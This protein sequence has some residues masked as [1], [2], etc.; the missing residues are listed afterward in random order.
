[1]VINS[2]YA[3][4]CTK[5]KGSI[6]VG[7]KVVWV[8]TE[9]GVYHADSDKCAPPAEHFQGLPKLPT[10]RPVVQVD[11]S[12]KPLADVM[13][14]V[15]LKRPTLRLNSAMGEIVLS[16]TR[17]GVQPGSVAIKVAGN[18]I[19]CVRPSGE[20]SSLLRNTNYADLRTHLLNIATDKNSLIAAA[21]DYAKL[22]NNCSFCG[23]QLTNDY[24]V[25][26]GYGPICAENWGLPHALNGTADKIRVPGMSDEKHMKMMKM[27]MEDDE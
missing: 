27:L 7:E 19:G 18:F 21:L 22:T 15:G 8:R 12:M 16:L 23:L 6:A 17:T 3:T 1:M 2:R 26:V 4:T 11:Y 9:K 20:C 10:P 24:S 5:C 13:Q 25:I 14:A